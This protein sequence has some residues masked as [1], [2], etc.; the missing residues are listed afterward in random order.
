MIEFNERENGW[1]P[2]EIAYLKLLLLTGVNYSE[3][4][5]RFKRL[6][7]KGFQYRSYH[8]IR[9]TASRLE[10][11]VV[12]QRKFQFKRAVKELAKRSGVTV[13][14]ETDRNQQLI[15]FSL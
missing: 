10:L 6:S 7:K 9:M 8:S 13:E 1:Q 11:T 15:R 5:R 12:N 14:F 3:I 2:W 4:A